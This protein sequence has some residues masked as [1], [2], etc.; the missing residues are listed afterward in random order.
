MGIMNYKRQPKFHAASRVI[1][2][3]KLRRKSQG[4]TLVEV[5]VGMGILALA[6]IGTLT[7]ASHSL[8]QLQTMRE[9]SRANQILQQKM[10]D[11]RLL[12]FTS[13]QALPGTFTDPN[14]THGMY[15]GTITQQV[16]L[17]D[18]NGA[19]QSIKLT[20]QVTWTGRNGR[21]RTLTLCSVFTNYGLNTYVF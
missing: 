1:S 13:I 9:F 18:N 4:L 7:T 8:V 14:D 2:N 19:T 17:T 20:V 11:I 6:I 5:M 15:A 16:Y 12:N 3:L 10:E 21:A